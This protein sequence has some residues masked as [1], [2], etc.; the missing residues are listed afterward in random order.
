MKNKKLLLVPELREML[1]VGDSK[2]LQNFRESGHP[3][4]IAGLIF[5]FYVVAARARSLSPEMSCRIAYMLEGYPG[6]FFD[7]NG[8]ENGN[9]IVRRIAP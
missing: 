6:H 5:V 8:D 9:S 1:V 4:V 7:R 3:G 2:A